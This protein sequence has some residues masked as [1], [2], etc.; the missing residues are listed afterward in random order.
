MATPHIAG[1]LACLEGNITPAAMSTKLKNLRL[2]GVLTLDKDSSVTFI[3]LFRLIPL[4][5]YFSF[6]YFERPG[7]QRLRRGTKR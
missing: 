4:T 7:A 6:G 2:K 5:K 3:I 1:L